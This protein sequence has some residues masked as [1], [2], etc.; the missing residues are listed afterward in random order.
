MWVS[1]CVCEQRDG[2]EGWMSECD[3]CEG[4]VSGCE[5]LTVSVSVRMNECV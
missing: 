4:A 5:L 3:R 2:C 1:L